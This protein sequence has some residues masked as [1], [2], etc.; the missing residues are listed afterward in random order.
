MENK[1]ISIQIDTVDLVIIAISLSLL[2]CN[3]D[4][5]YE[6]NKDLL[7]VSK[8]EFFDAINQISKSIDKC[9]EVID[10]E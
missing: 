9:M 8:N 10:F 1:R 4:D 2:K 6:D 7:L 5:I 3:S